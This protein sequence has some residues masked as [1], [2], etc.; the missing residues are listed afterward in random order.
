MEWVS[1]EGLKFGRPE[2]T[3]NLSSYGERRLAAIMFTD[4]VGYATLAQKNEPRAIRLL[5]K[6]REITRPIFAKHGGREIKTMGDAFLVDFKSALAAVQCAVEIQKVHHM[7]NEREPEKK[8]HVRVGIHAG[9]VIYRDGD[10]YGDAVNVASRIE[11]LAEGDEVCISDQVYDQVRNKIRYALSRLESQ[12]LKN[13]TFQVDVYKVQLPWNKKGSRSVVV[14]SQKPL[15]KVFRR[16]PREARAE[17][18]KT[19]NIGELILRLTLKNKVSDVEVLNEPQIP[20][21]LARFSE[22]VDYSRG[23]TLCIVSGIHTV[24]VVID[25]KN[26]INLRA[27]LPARNILSVIN[28]LAEVIVTLSDAALRTR[29]VIAKMSMELANNDINIFEYIHATPN[30]IIVVEKKDSLRTYQ[31]LEGL[32]SNQN[33]PQH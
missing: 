33:M 2:N 22:L 13:I 32:A 16:N 18:V 23:E 14:P 3:I 12:D 10:L 28:G 6:H 31:V 8:L 5:Q 29:G 17:R 30:V 24:R 19:E 26:L 21:G 15:T 7:Y 11:P 1:D 9:D 27:T 4:L 25:D 20:A